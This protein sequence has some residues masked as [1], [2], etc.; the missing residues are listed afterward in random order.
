MIGRFV[1][2]IG[3]EKITAT[4]ED[5]GAVL[6]SASYSFSMDGWQT[7]GSVAAVPSTARA[8]FAT[9]ADACSAVIDYAKQHVMDLIEGKS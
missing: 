5:D 7:F 6:S 4:R 3:P 8:W 1:L 2:D 9:R